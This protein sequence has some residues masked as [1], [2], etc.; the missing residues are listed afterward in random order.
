MSQTH[1][2]NYRIQVHKPH[3]HITHTRTHAHTH[4][5][6]NIINK[7]CNTVRIIRIIVVRICMYS[8]TNFNFF[9]FLL[10]FKKQ[11]ISKMKGNF[12]GLC[13]HVQTVYT[14]CCCFFFHNFCKM[15]MGASIKCTIYNLNMN[16][17]WYLWMY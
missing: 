11:K 10:F 14:C 4:V 12:N 5:D 2:H 16:F 7:W 9:L 6:L 17:I 13:V 15:R 3:L 8:T 1:L